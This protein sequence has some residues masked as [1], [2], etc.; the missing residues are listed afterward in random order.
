MASKFPNKI[1]AI[2]TSRLKRLLVLH[3]TPINVI[4]SHGPQ[5]FLILGLASFL[6]AFRIYPFPT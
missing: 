5:R 2:S 6:D 3:L 4:I 1:R